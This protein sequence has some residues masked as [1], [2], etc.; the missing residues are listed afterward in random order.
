MVNGG[1]ASAQCFYS[2]PGKQ[3]PTNHKGHAANRR[4]H[5]Q[6]SFAGDCVS[7]EAARE[8]KYSGQEAASACCEKSGINSGAKESNREYS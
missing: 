4:D 8:Q 7:I 5:C 1:V 2:R 3:A 6:F